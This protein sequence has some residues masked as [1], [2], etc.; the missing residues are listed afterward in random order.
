MERREALVDVGRRGLLMHFGELDVDGGRAGYDGT[1][2]DRPLVIGA[3]DMVLNGNRLSPPPALV[4]LAF[5]DVV[6]TG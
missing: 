6:Q 3:F 5:S 1:G 4:A 2:G